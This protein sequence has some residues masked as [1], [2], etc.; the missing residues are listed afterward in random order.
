MTELAEEDVCHVYP[1][2][3]DEAIEMTVQALTLASKVIPTSCYRPNL[4]PF[5][6][7]ELDD[8][9]KI[10]VVKF[11]IWKNEG[12]PRNKDAKSWIEH[13]SA[14]KHFLKAIKKISKDYENKRMIEAIESNTTDRSVFWRH[15]KKCCGSSGSKILAIKDSSDKVEYEMDEI[16]EVWRR[17]FAS[18]STPKDDSTY[19]S[20]HYD[21]V[22]KKV[23]EFNM[24]D[25]SSA[26]LDEPFNTR[27][28]Q[29]AVNKLHKMKACGFNG[30]C[31]EHIKFG[32][33]LLIICLTMIF[34]LICKMEYVPV[35]F[36][37]GIQVPLFKGKNLCSTDTNSYRG[38][39]LLSTFNKI[40]EMLIW[41]RIEIWWR[42]NE[43]ISGFQGA[44]RKGQ[45]CVHTS[46][47]LQE[48]IASALEN[49]K[50]V[51][52][53]YFDVSKAFDTV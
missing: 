34:N 4:K 5:W 12:R 44:C 31:A 22:N 28:I 30:V 19:D 38:I 18:L 51:F 50:K 41:G 1:K 23:K 52:V 35:N 2:G 40:Y 21:F 13:K 25:D 49:N 10:K 3:I 36:R 9:K 53:S 8:L 27:E 20:E 14:K 15:L 17:H 45:S 32:G 48:T 33:N 42:E 24:K 16:L 7:T 6:N 46:L 29:K 37:R 47:L 39:T 26:F 43:V 11:K